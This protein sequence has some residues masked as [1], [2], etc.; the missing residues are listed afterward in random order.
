MPT[1]Y[2]LRPETPEEK[3]NPPERREL[4][5]LPDMGELQGLLNG[6]MIEHVTVYFDGR[7]AHMFVDDSSAMKA[8]PRINGR[9]TAIYHNA[10]RARAGHPGVLLYRKI[11]RF[12]LERDF[13]KD[14]PPICGIAL[15]WPA[16]APDWE[17]EGAP[18]LDYEQT[19]PL[20]P[21]APKETPWG[22]T[23]DAL[24]V[25]TGIWYVSTAASGGIWLNVE[26]RDELPKWARRIEVPEDSFYSEDD[27]A[28]VP[29]LVWPELF[30]SHAP[31]DSA[32]LMAHRV[33]EETLQRA[34]PRSWEVYEK[35]K[36]L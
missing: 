26:R 29:H 22:P 35:S 11:D 12:P 15:L 5:E 8:N 34:Y 28:C 24:E 6:A 31:N 21:G 4:E 3:D 7:R 32:R 1:L 10:T 25:A 2:I 18:W 13:I 9:A 36:R 16:P 20:P 27:A 23:L 14:M 17:P 33:A 30:G 19:R